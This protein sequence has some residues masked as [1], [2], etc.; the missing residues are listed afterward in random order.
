MDD[1]NF[2]LEITKAV[3]WILVQAEQTPYGEVAVKL[4]IHAGKLSRVERTVTAKIQPNREMN[5]GRSDT[6]ADG[7]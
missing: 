2:S 7:N 1:E 6:L 3:S 4:I 5:D